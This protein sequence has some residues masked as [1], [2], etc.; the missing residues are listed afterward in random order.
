MYHE[1]RRLLVDST[2]GSRVHWVDE[3]NTSE[4][5]DAC[6]H[7]RPAALFL[8]SMCNSKSVAVPD[9]QT[10]MLELAASAR[11]D[12]CVVIDNTCAS[13]FCQPLD[14]AVLNSRVRPLLF[15]SLT[16]YA[17][18]GLDRAAAGMIV[19]PK[20]EATALDGLREHLGTNVA[21]VC[22]STIPE[23]NRAL[24][25]RRLRRIERNA[26]S[27]A[28]QVMCC[29]IEGTSPVTGAV[30]PGLEAHSCHEA[31][32]RLGFFGGFFAVEFRPEWDCPEVHRRLVSALIHEARL[33][34]LNLVA[35]ASFGLNVTRVYRTATENGLGPFVRVSAGTED[36]IEV[37]RLKEV[38][39]SAIDALSL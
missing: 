15:E 18:F 34:K 35:G 20:R 31:A 14:L 27:L 30:Y 7:L 8:D 21:D 19:A 29:A 23:P 33:R 11:R 26:Q 16:K 28:R 32:S 13:I 24:L 22:A 25:R 38:F 1:C 2:L 36:L 6:R 5:I 10:V 9:L 3:A 4:I 39:A 37:E 17:Q 12:V